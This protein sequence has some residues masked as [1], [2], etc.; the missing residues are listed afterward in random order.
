MS[1]S[2]FLGST[3][4]PNK[5]QKGPAA[6]KPIC[7]TEKKEEGGRAETNNAGFK[8]FSSFIWNLVVKKEN[9][10]IGPQRALYGP[11][12]EAYL[13]V[14]HTLKVSIVDSVHTAEEGSQ[15]GQYRGHYLGPYR[16]LW[17]PTLFGAL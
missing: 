5:L 14:C 10:P 2:T 7:W 15:I 9:G 11:Y 3:K 16:A 12:S 8:K 17:G 6:P 1:K 13:D 4:R